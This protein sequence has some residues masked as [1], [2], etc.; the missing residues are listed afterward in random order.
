MDDEVLARADLVRTA[1][2]IL[3]IGEADVALHV[4]GPWSSGALV[5]ARAAALTNR[6]AAT[7]GLLIVN[8][9]VDVARS[10]QLAVHLGRRSLPVA[11]ARELLGADSLIGASVHAAEEAR[12]AVA[13][14]ADYVIAGTVYSSRSHPQRAGEGVEWLRKVCST[15]PA[16]VV[17]IGGITPE[18]APAAIAAGAHGIAVLAGVWSAADPEEAVRTYLTQLR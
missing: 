10:L 1:T 18:R 5:Y 15:T 6:A 4:R 14:S 7:G 17:A 16:P 9:R 3:E 2:R 13:A 8:D 12:R 11:V